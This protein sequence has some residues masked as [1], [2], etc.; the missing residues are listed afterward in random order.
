MLPSAVIGHSSG[1]V[2]AAYAAG[3]IDLVSACKISYYRG[4]YA[5]RISRSGHGGSMLAVGLSETDILAHL[6][7]SPLSLACINSPTNVTVAGP[8]D[9]IKSLHARLQTENIFSAVLKTGVA[10]HSSIMTSVAE[11]YGEAIKDLARPADV[12][13]TIPIVSTI[14][15]ELVIDL[16]CFTDAQYW[17]RNLVSPVKFSQALSRLTSKQR[18]TRKLGQ[19]A[20]IDLHDIIE[21]GP[22][23]ALKRPIQETL[24]H[25]KRQLQYHQSLSRHESAS[26]C[27]LRLTG[28][29]FCLGYR[30]DFASV[31]RLDP[32]KRYRTLTDL[33]SYSFSNTRSYW[34]ESTLSAQTRR[35]HHFPRPLLGAPVADWNPLEPKWRQYL[36]VQALPWLA[37]HKVD[38]AILL[39]GA[40]M[41]I[42]ALEA[43]HQ[44][45]PPDAKIIGYWIKEA[46]FSIPIVIPAEEEQHAEIETNYR[47]KWSPLANGSAWS[48]VR[49][50]LRSGES[51]QEA[52]RAVLQVELDQP[53][54]G[55]DD[56]AEKEMHASL[57]KDRYITL[58]APCDKAI[59]AK[60]VYRTYHKMGLEYGPSFQGLVQ[61]SWNQN[62]TCKAG[63]ILPQENVSNSID[64]QNFLIHPA[65]LD[66]LAHLMW[67]PLTHGGTRV[68]PTALPTRIRDAWISNV[69]LRDN[70][71]RP[72]H[73]VA[74]AFKRDFRVVEGTAIMLNDLDEPIL[75]LGTLEFTTITRPGPDSAESNF[76]PLF[77]SLRDK[78]DIDL[79]EK[80][81]LPRFIEPV[82]THS[83]TEASFNHDVHEALQWFIGSAL[84]EFDEVMLSVLSPHMRLY[85]DWMRLQCKTNPTIN[86]A[87]TSNVAEREDLLH[88]IEDT[89]ERGKV[90][91]A[92]GR[93]LLSIICGKVDPLE[94]LF[95]SGLA[96]GFYTDLVRSVSA[97]AK[98]WNYLDALAFKN[99]ALKIL[100]VGAGTGSMTPFVL[101]PLLAES[102]A[103]EVY[104]KF[105]EYDFTDVSAAF[106]EKAKAK[107]ADSMPIGNINFKVF[108]LEADPETQ[109]L[110]CASYD[111]IVAASVI[112]ATK[113]LKH[114]L[115]RLRKLLKP[116]GKLILFEVIQPECIRAAFVFGTLPGWWM[117]TD[118][119]DGYRTL[120]PNISGEQW[121]EVLSA[122]GFSVDATIRDHDDD[123]CHEFGFIFASAV[124]Q[125]T[126]AVDPD[127]RTT[128]V[129][130]PN[131]ETQLELALSI[132]RAIGNQGYPT[133]KMLTLDD[134]ITP[135]S[136]AGQRIIVLAEMVSPLLRH[137]TEPQFDAINLIAA[138]GK[139]VLWV[140]RTGRDTEQ[141]ADFQMIDGLARV[142]RTENPNRAFV[143]LALQD[144]NNI[145]ANANAI[146]KVLHELENGHWST[147]HCEMEYF[148]HNDMLHIRRLLEEDAL[149]NQI[150]AKVTPQLRQE[151][152]EFAS[153]LALTVHSPGLLDSLCF[154]A[155]IGGGAELPLGLG[156]V[157]ID[158]RAV[159]V[160]FRDVLIALGA[161]DSDRLGVECT[162]IV[163]RAGTKSA[164]QP[165]E[166]VIV[167]KMGCASSLV[168]CSSEVVVKIP[169]GMSF[170]YAASFPTAGVT[171]YYSLIEMARLQ[172]GETIL[173]HAGAGGTGQMC[174]QLAQKVGAE[175]YVTTSSETKKAFLMTTYGISSDHIFYSRNTSFAQSMR[176]AT[177]GRGV[178]VLVNS[179]AGDSLIASW[180]LMA[181]HGRFVEL[182]R[183]DIR[184]NSN[185]PM[186]SFENN[187]SFIGVA[188]DYICDH[189]PALLGKMLRAVTD[190]IANGVLR[191]PFPIRSYSVSEVVDAFR[192]LQSGASIGKIV[193][194]MD[195]S[196][197]VQVNTKFESLTELSTDTTYRHIDFNNLTGPSRKMLRMSSQADWVD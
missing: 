37:D 52:C 174:I 126:L 9:H 147:E 81:Y 158:V 90:Y 186:M 41:I 134:L 162:G 15:A 91:V 189:R 68:V 19:K 172:A 58:A 184:G 2:A 120:G 171:A 89:N 180:E 12:R 114:T 165:G 76:Q 153:P 35:R 128:I 130:S 95:T 117:S 98:L 73:G 176:Q 14:T 28:Q 121:A 16:N 31:N 138:C 155:D 173:I 1:E 177:G 131:C 104:P 23:S 132:Q 80:S 127:R 179:L 146:T 129:V 183:A 106:F 78:P 85:I 39:P 93:Q 62:D 22:G 38:G 53:R 166:R 82:Q 66:I 94:V 109:G 192:Y 63:I 137:I 4:L 54:T 75:T 136:L 83:E 159:G 111:L 182:G 157:E 161:L 24:K 143:T 169:E 122:T 125:G 40:A 191:L 51:I 56:G 21:I 18:S 194:T 140:T 49:I 197:V 71:K 135:Q 61:P 30:I 102:N 123:L 64:S 99:P 43:A 17:V 86:S 20:Q 142:L 46:T 185:L 181:P 92:F 59:D 5:A 170:E 7:S 195:P 88:R 96:E 32:H 11:D 69:G 57:L 168:R 188:I 65:T 124:D 3:A 87:T 47:T 148:E 149:D 116:G 108:D 152:W 13:A 175:V 163:R 72:M 193:L 55:L 145:E 187:V 110:E 42:L 144:N 141:Y 29:L 113:D 167:A 26:T 8:E 118:S 50:C 178:D 45:A 115:M 154:M 164:I 60:A 156:E 74:R 25:D 139:G 107:L 103:N 48:E 84:Q 160:N 44:M 190:M 196:D 97:G 27:V 119:R 77:F 34:Q 133:C 105:S 101:A 70:R 151:T 33:P 112:H 36:S 6:D 150:Q 79:I 100:E 67:V 10:Y